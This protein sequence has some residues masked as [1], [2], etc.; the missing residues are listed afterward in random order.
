MALW[1]ILGDHSGIAVLDCLYMPPLFSTLDL[2]VRPARRRTIL[3]CLLCASE[4][5]SA[6]FSGLVEARGLPALP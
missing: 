2:R 1:L 5:Q 4:R 3:G 6:D